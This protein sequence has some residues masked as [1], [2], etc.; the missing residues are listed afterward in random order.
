MQISDSQLD[1][2][3]R[4]VP[5]PDG[6]IERLCALP[7]VDDDGLDQAVREVEMPRGLL[8]RL[9]R[10]PLADDD[11]LDAALRNV[12][13]PKRLT[14]A[15]RRRNVKRDRLVRLS[16]LVVAASVIVAVS[17]SFL[18][19][20]LTSLPNPHD[21]QANP[22]PAPKT[23]EAEPLEASLLAEAESEEPAEPPQAG[24]PELGP[25]MFEDR[26]P[27]RPADV[28]A[29]SMPSEVDPLAT[30][31][32]QVYST[33][34]RGDELLPPAAGLTSRGVAWPKDPAWNEWF[35]A[36]Y[37]THPFVSPKSS[38]QA[39]S[40]VVP[41]WVDTSSYELARRYLE[42]ELRQKGKK[43]GDLP[44]HDQVRLEDFL[45]AMNYDF[46]QPDKQ[47]LAVTMAAGPS[48]FRPGFCLLQVGV[49]ARQVREDKRAPVHLVLAVDTSGSMAA[50]RR[51]EFVRRAV[52]EL[53]EQQ[54][55]N[56]GDRISL[57]CFSSGTH[58]LVQE[59]APADMGYL[60]DAA[61]S[62]A[63]DG[64][65]NA[66]AGISRALS[67]AQEAVGPGRP[68]ARVVLVTDGLLDSEPSFIEHI[69]RRIATA[70]GHDI[71]LDVI[72][73]G[74]GK[75]PEPALAAFA[76]LGGGKVYHAANAD[77]IRWSLQEA[78][79]GRSRL[80]ARDAQLKVVF[81]P[82]T[83]LEYRLLGHEH[84]PQ[85]LGGPANPRADFRNGQSATA[86]FE[87]RMLSGT[88]GEV[89]TAELT[90]YAPDDRP[91]SDRP[92]GDQGQQQARSRIEVKDF[93][94]SFEK[95]KLSLQAAAVVA[96][97][98]EVLRWSPFV[99]QGRGDSPPLVKLWE[100]MQRVD[101]RLFQRAAFGDFVRM[102][103]LALKAKPGWVGPR[104]G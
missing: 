88:P 7:L 50:G 97:A 103:E 13:V 81:S 15:W 52:I 20:W 28:A 35:L 31:A 95:A 75:E 14:A 91:G 94:A 89:A 98:A 82:K 67:L 46:P 17:L 102:V 41:L 30:P 10:I 80:V 8:K 93:A 3:L 59:V 65:T 45:A 36:F 54:H 27:A 48:P 76:K 74:F 61:R 66:G 47:A 56:P 2:K 58:V 55:F 62:L 64:P 51:L 83:V 92:A 21:M 87:V 12:P 29:L 71:P 96:Q 19:A 43:E 38:S 84:L 34:D 73:L 22:A 44:P 18:A 78:L 40:C 63:S 9:R 85:D 6:F 104:R 49:R 39:Q 33:G 37:R 5:L 90:W 11:G 23:P 99:Q 1:A 26:R 69:Q 100:V 57:V 68:A 4:A 53:A 32:E 101:S 77:Q 60:I 42:G 72:D 79:T 25:P 16:R 24:A 70:A 86:L